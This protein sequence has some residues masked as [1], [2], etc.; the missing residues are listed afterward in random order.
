MSFKIKVCYKLTFFF[1]FVSKL[2]SSNKFRKEKRKE[3]IKRSILN[4]RNIRSVIS[5]FSPSPMYESLR[6]QT[7]FLELLNSSV[8]DKLC[9]GT[10]NH[11]LSFP[12]LLFMSLSKTLSLVL[13]CSNGNQWNRKAYVQSADSFHSKIRFFFLFS[14]EV[15]CGK[16][17]GRIFLLEKLLVK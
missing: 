8:C 3:D 6:K 17:K 12:N 4:L 9:H 10:Y 15:V 14:E 5:I 13:M 11:R 7:S 16:G 1:F 2:T